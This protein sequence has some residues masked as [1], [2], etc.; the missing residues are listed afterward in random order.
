MA[1]EEKSVMAEEEEKS[2]HELLYDMSQQ[3][4][5]IH[6]KGAAYF[7]EQLEDV[8]SQVPG[9]CGLWQTLLDFQREYTTYI[10]SVPTE[11]NYESL[12]QQGHDLQESLKALGN[13]A[14]TEAVFKSKERRDQWGDVIE[15]LARIAP[16]LRRFSGSYESPR[17]TKA[18]AV[19]RGADDEPNK[20]MGKK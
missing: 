19:A 14:R 20:T 7:R 5:E 1:E 2:V 18:M 15:Q 3:E 8:I 17:F 13:F 12:I 11:E 16:T 4:V 10:N 6:V 9:N